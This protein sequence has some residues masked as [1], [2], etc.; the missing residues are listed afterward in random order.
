M[1]LQEL[2]EQA[3]KLPV[4]DRLTNL[5]AVITFSNL[6]AVS[7]ATSLLTVPIVIP[8]NV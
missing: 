5:I 8:T 2:K 6:S 4:S 7:K 1:S 3:C